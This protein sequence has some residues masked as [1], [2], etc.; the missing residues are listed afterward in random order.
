[1]ARIL[2]ATLAVVLLLVGCA[3]TND[4]E[5][6]GLTIDLVEDAN[7]VLEIPREFDQSEYMPTNVTNFYERQ[8]I[9]RS[10][11]GARFYGRDEIS[12][13]KRQFQDAIAYNRYNNKAHFALGLIYYEEQE[14]AKAL[15]HFR[16]IRRQ[17][18]RTF[19]YDIDYYTAAQMI[20]SYFPFQAKVTA[21]ESSSE[22]G[23][24]SDTRLILN[25]GA[26]QGVREGMEFQV[27]RVGNVIRDIDSAQVI[28][29]KRSP[30]VR[31]RVI[32]VE[33]NNA[34]AEPIRGTET[35]TGA[36]VQIDDLLET[37]YLQQ[38]E[39]ETESTLQSGA[40]Q[41]SQE[42]VR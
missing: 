5:E 20:L 33:P 10:E 24:R 31:V 7:H 36:G 11:L 18:A 14:F 23:G 34:V 8:S 25:K 37:Q 15:S 30:L 4:S 41:V 6:D 3:T 13:A 17:E 27:Y 22:T 40:E 38:L 21:F 9:L 12:K 35:L 29:Q 28:G 39:A 32:R 2:G 42:A 16:R 19:P 26:N 1:M